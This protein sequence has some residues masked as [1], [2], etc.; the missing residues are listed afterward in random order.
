MPTGESGVETVPSRL[1]SLA[2][3][4]LAR[5]GKKRRDTVSAAFFSYFTYS[6]ENPLR[7]IKKK[8]KLTTQA[9][10]SAGQGITVL[11]LHHTIQIQAQQHTKRIY[12]GRKFGGGRRVP[13]L[14]EDRSGRSGQRVGRVLHHFEE[15]LFSTTNQHSCTR[16]VLLFVPALT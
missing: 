15:N 10:L 4:E 6:F 16:F 14:L 3:Y 8:K 1:K 13:I 12:M 9:C 5:T 2:E 11:N 7:G